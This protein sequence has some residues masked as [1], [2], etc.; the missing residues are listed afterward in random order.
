MRQRP[1]AICGQQGP[2]LAA[3]V[4]KFRLLRH[5]RVGYQLAQPTAL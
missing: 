1:R 5:M 2:V 4:S 3:A